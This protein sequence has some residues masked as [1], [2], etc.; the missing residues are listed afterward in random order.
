MHTELHQFFPLPSYD[1]SA[2]LILSLEHLC[3]HLGRISKEDSSELEEEWSDNE[4][5]QHDNTFLHDASK[6]DDLLFIE[7]L[8]GQAIDETC[9]VGT[10]IE[11]DA[12]SQTAQPVFMQP[13]DRI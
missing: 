10:C 8:K 5:L 6:S 4:S 2:D 9:P 13:A 1:M 11:L 7:A 3:S 12:D